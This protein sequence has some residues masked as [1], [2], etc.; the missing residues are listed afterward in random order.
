MAEPDPRP[1]WA[2]RVQPPVPGEPTQDVHVHATSVAQ[3]EAIVRRRRLEIVPGATRRSEVS[4]PSGEEAFIQAPG[5][6][7]CTSCGYVL[8]GLVVRS[9][10]VE[11]PECAFPQ[12]VVAYNP[13]PWEGRLDHA[14]P[15]H[16]PF[17]VGWAVAAVLFVIFL[18]T[19]LM[20]LVGLL[21]I[22]GP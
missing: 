10:I 22:T 13:E 12:V 21:V 19:V 16:K 20:A 14:Y 4:T 17:G 3:A 6:L 1:L 18:S 11:C 2:V 9:G 7:T 5:P 15:K 8:D